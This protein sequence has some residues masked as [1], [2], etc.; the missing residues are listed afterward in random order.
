MAS[1]SLLVFGAAADVLML[2]SGLRRDPGLRVV[3]DD[4]I[5]ASGG[6]CRTGRNRLD[7]AEGRTQTTN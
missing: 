2:S 1:R 3:S 6:S 5:V 7:E 4:C